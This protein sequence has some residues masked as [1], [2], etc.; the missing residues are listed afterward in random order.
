M[1]RAT[2]SS[3]EG[4][5]VLPPDTARGAAPEDPDE[6]RGVIR[7]CALVHQASTGGNGVDVRGDL[8]RALASWIDQLPDRRRIYP[9]ATDR[10][11]QPHAA[12][13]YLRAES[14]AVLSAIVAF[15]IGGRIIA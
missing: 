3:L 8:G 11:D 6:P 7:T 5:V 9:P 4:L 1:S 2:P 13:D 14:S 10:C 12:S 15:L